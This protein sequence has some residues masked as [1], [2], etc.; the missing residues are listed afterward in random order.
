M[1]ALRQ[2]KTQLKSKR[3]WVKRKL[4]T[5]PLWYEEPDYI[6]IH[7]NKTGGSSVEKALGLPFEHLTALEKKAEVGANK[8]Q[9]KFTFSFVRNPFD[10]V[11][12]HYRYR[13]RTNQ[14]Q[15]QTSPISFNEWVRRSYGDRDP[16]YYDKPKMFMPQVEWLADAQGHLLVD[17]VYRFEQLAADFSDLARRFDLNV[18]L[19]H[20]KASKKV[21]YRD[22]F[23]DTSK[24]I[25]SDRFA[26]DLA[27]FDYHF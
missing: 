26:G 7:I 25:I 2:L 18:R 24:S 13:V 12:S 5:F 21:S 10:K 3:R 15:M 17:Q 9:S 16:Q 22:Y 19:P 14:T 23:D 6:F 4:H 27:T 1:N 11:C 8:W 20:L